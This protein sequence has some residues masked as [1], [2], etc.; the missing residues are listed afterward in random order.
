M[1]ELQVV[2]ADIGRGYGK[3]YTEKDGVEHKGI[4]KSVV[5]L[6]R[7]LEWEKYSNPMYF[8]ASLGEQTFKAVFCGEV[9]EKEGFAT[10][11]NSKDSKI[12]DT[13]KK[14]FLGALS[15]IP[16]EDKINVVLGV[17]NREWNKSNLNAVIEE[18]KG[19]TIEITDHV[20][21]RVKK[22]FINDITI[23]KES[24]AALLYHVQ[25]NKPNNTNDNVMVNIGFRTTEISYYDNNLRYNDKKSKSLELGNQTVLEFV[26]KHHPKRSLEEIDSSNRY[27]DLK[28]AGYNM[29]AENIDQLVESILVNLDEI[30]LFACGGV[31]N[32]INLPEKFKKVEDPQMITAKG[33]FLVGEKMFKGGI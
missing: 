3:V 11:R 22:T 8:D 24:D 25:H 23:F 5:A 31:T 16:L 1:S 21:K 30:N 19:K 4:F 17:P 20:N 10:I 15:C 33:L 27:D 26:Q 13:A 14:I 29:L 6:G 7:E 9:A 2:G 28:E 32:K 12:T 18:Y